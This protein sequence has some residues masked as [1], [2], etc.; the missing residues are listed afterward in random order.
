MMK[1]S[2]ISMLVGCV[3]NIILDP[4]FI[5]GAGFIPAMGVEGAALATGIGQAATLVIYL[6][7]YRRVKLPVKFRLNRNSF[8]TEKSAKG[9]T[10]WEYRPP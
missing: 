9:C 8:W 3:V 4:L 10:G 7:I 6:V 1:V 2:M 5:F